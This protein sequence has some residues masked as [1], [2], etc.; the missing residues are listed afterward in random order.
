[1]VAE[2]RGGDKLDDGEVYI[3]MIKVR[4][5]NTRWTDEEIGGVC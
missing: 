2:V 3:G 5:M 4:E 1:M